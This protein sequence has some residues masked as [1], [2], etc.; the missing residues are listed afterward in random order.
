MCEHVWC[1]CVNVKIAGLC[2]IDV[3]FIPPEWDYITSGHLGMQRADLANN[4]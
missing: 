1:I 2:L 4:I 3:L